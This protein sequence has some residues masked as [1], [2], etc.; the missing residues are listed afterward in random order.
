M[1]LMIS[2]LRLPRLLLAAGVTA[3]CLVT[4]TTG[5]ETAKDEGQRLRLRGFTLVF[6]CWQLLV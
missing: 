2:L 6:D 1:R 5:M 4:L 3:E